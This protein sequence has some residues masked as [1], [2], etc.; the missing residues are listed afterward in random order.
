MYQALIA[1]PDEQRVTRGGVAV[2]HGSMQFK[3][4]QHTGLSPVRYETGLK[5]PE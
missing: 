1:L 4:A 3:S 5:E 2:I